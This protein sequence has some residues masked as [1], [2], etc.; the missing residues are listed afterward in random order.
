MLRRGVMY[1][2]SPGTTPAL[3]H[4]RRVVLTPGQ[5][6]TVRDQAVSG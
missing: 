2:A 5:M 3:I 4:A 1:D 6:F